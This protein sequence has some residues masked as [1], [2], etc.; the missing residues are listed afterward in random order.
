MPFTRKIR[1][2]FLSARQVRAIRSIRVTFLA[3]LSYF[4]TGNAFCN[5]NPVKF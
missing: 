2:T 3:I 1:V 4:F 5:F